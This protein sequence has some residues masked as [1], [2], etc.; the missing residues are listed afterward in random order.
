M[1]AEQL[2]ERFGEQH[3]LAF[4]LVLARVAPLFL[5]APL[6]SSKSFPRPRPRRH[7]RRARRRHLAGRHPGARRRARSPP[8]IWELGALMVKELLVGMAFSFGIAALFAALSTAGALLDTMIG[9]SLGGIL[10]PVTGTQSSVLTQLYTMIGVL[11]FIAI[12]GDGWVIAGPRPHLRG[13]A[14]ARGARRSRS[15]T[16]GAQLAFSNIFGAAIMVCAPVLIA[17]VITDAALGIVSRVVPQINV[18]AVGFPA[19]IAVGFLLIGASLPFAAGLALRRAPAL[20]RHRPADAEGGVMAENKTEKATPKK[21]DD[22]RKKGQVARSM[23]LNGA[24]VLLAA[25]LALSAFAPGMMRRMSQATRDLL[26]L[27][28]QPD[29]VGAE[30]VPQIFGIVGSAW[31]YSLAPIAAVCLVAGVLISVG[32]VGF[33]PSAR[34]A[35]ARP[36]EAQPAPGREADLRHPRAVRERQVDREDR[37]RRRHRAA[38]AAAQAR[39]AGRARRHA[40]RRAAAEIGHT[41]ARASRRRPRPPTS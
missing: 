5:L 41:G 34:G 39:G 6:F 29:T 2:I 24:V 36:E 15:I 27:I 1:T 20:R 19:K 3:V 23:D 30:T 9:F 31:L 26:G 40:R 18:F 25:L 10:D 14:A 11:I 37:R 22:A 4:A 33:K 21:R 7:R 28:S 8:G 12:G 17:L 13:G 16:A 32:Q 35:Q 38:H